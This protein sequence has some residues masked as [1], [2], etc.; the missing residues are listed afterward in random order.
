[1]IQRSAILLLGV[2]ALCAPVGPVAAGQPAGTREIRDRFL[3]YCDLACE[4][5]N[6]EEYAPFEEV[7]RTKA[8]PRTHHFPFFEDAYA[9]R[10]L[11][12][13]Y[14]ITGNKK[15]L[16]AAARWTDRVV[17][18]QGRMTPKGA[19]YLNYAR[20]PD[21]KAGEWYVADSG[22]VGLGVLA[23]AVRTADAQQK[24]RYLD[25]VRSLARLVIDNYV[26]KEGGITDGLWS[27]Y[28]GEWYCSTATF[29][30]LMLLAYAETKDPEYLK[31][32]LG[33]LDWL[34][35]HDFSKPQPPATGAL[36][37]CQVFYCG[38]FY[39][40]A[41]KD[42]APT[43]PRRKAAAKQIGLL[44]QWLNDHQAGRGAKK[45][46][47][48]F[49]ADTYMAG[50]PYLQYIFARELPE[51]HDQASAADQ[52]MRYVA[53]LLSKDG[54]AKDGRPAAA[55]TLIAWELMTWAMTSYAE[56]LCP[57]ALLRTSR[58]PINDPERA[59]D[60]PLGRK[61]VSSEEKPVR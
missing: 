50:M 17:A 7:Y 9:V 8:D 41:L 32:G 48:Y 19:Y 51:H 13:A 40:V 16:A 49:C 11:C 3:L 10:A 54:L 52:E 60:I 31:I 38:E 34:N 30:S 27:A 21:A 26:G 2:S 4:E 25:S 1:M 56:K 22:S 57:G 33:A 61:P 29:G 39:A 12:V 55:G 47:D 20:P 58:D 35:R 28:A 53:G 18:Y 15:Y 45:P 37:A 46:V 44:V 43:D 6:K 42:L 24:A 5:L 14:D 59:L 23:T 36:G